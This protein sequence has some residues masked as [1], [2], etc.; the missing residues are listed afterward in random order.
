MAKRDRDVFPFLN[1]Q[2]RDSTLPVLVSTNSTGAPVR[3][4]VHDVPNLAHPSGAG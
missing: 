4:A 3:A 1:S 2:N